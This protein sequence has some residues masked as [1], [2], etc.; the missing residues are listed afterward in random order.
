MSA[1]R[2][3]IG[4]PRRISSKAAGR[5]DLVFAALLTNGRVMVVWQYQ[6]LGPNLDPVDVHCRVVDSTGKPVTAERR[7]TKEGIPGRQTPKSIAALPNGECVFS[8][9]HFDA[10]GGVYRVALQKLAPSGKRLGAPVV[11]KETDSNSPYGAGSV[12]SLASGQPPLDAIAGKA[13]AFKGFQFAISYDG[14]AEDTRLWGQA[15]KANG[16]GF[17]PWH[18]ISPAIR[19]SFFSERSPALLAIKSGVCLGMTLVDRKNPGDPLKIVGFVGDLTSDEPFQQQ[20]LRSSE[21][22]T[23][24]DDLGTYKLAPGVHAVGIVFAYSEDDEALL[25]LSKLPLDF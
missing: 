1:G 5:N 17:T 13:P 2:K 19:T 23:S 6:G 3:K 4:Q 7:A 18:V 10:A 25:Q 21:T 22:L 24:L 15:F 12:A 14:S 11:L 8:Y 20:T 16:T 9:V